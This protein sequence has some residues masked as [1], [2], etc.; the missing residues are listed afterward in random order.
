[1]RQDIAVDRLLA[2]GAD[3]TIRIR[4]DTVP[5]PEK[6]DTASSPLTIALNHGV[7][8]N[9]RYRM[10]IDPVITDLGAFMGRAVIGDASF[11]M[12]A[13]RIH[14]NDIAIDSIDAEYIYPSAEYLAAHPSPAEP[15]DSAAASVPWTVSCD[16]VRLIGGNALYAL[17]GARP[18][19]S[20]FDLDYIQATEIGIAVDSF[21]NRGTAVRVP[22]RGIHA[23]ERCGVRVNLTGL[24][25]MDS[26]AMRAENIAVT[27]GASRVSLDATLGMN[28]A[29]TG[30]MPVALRLSA[31]L[32]N[33]DLRRLAPPQM[34]Q[35]ADML[36]PYQPL[37]AEAELKGTM[38]DLDVKNIKVEIPQ[39]A[40]IKASGRMADMTDLDKARGNV[41]ISGWIADGKW[42]KPLLL[43]A[44][45][46]RGINIPPLTVEGEASLDRGVVDGSVTAHTGS[47]RLALEALWNNRATSYDID[48]RADDFPA[49]S[50]LP[51][52]GLRD[53]TARIN[54]SGQGFDVM[55]PRT[56]IDARIDLVKATYQG[57]QYQDVTLTANLAAGHAAVEAVSRNPYAAFDIKADGEIAA[58]P[59]RATI[60]GDITN[61]DLKAL[62]M[63]DTATTIAARLTGEVAFDPATKTRP[64]T[65]SSDI[66]IA[67]LDYR[68]GTMRLGARGLAL[69]FDA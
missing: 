17:D 46:G 1:M 26:S 25:D 40:G 69:K 18:A 56:D 60:D 14:A 54:A 43:D 5:E 33:E 64:M 42:A 66:D 38:A 58:L 9:V 51:D 24:F 11:D 49:Q 53:V 45:S 7:L 47:G 35:I 65:A 15:A 39:H 52:L 55:S 21:V 31:D 22:I 36:P 62:G 34:S 19:G 59:Y 6:T 48:L 30:D 4:P 10:S 13:K 50:I 67:S 41:S 32:A 2:E 63:T 8:E 57:H 27:T 23:R 44:K 28:S 29:K 37:L 3:V 61:L 16:K 68:A 12:L 20:G